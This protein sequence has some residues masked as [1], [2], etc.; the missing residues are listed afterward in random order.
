MLTDDELLALART[1]AVPGA[2][3]SSTNYTAIITYGR[4]VL[5]GGNVIYSPCSQHMGR[6][7]TL[8]MRAPTVRLV[9]PICNPPPP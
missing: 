5:A 7:V 8:V 1:A 2:Y 4:A 6:T 9:C 3:P